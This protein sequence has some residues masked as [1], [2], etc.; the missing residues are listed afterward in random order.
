[1]RA[2]GRNFHAMAEIHFATWSRWVA[3]TGSS[4]YAAG[5]SARERMAAAGYEVSAG[6]TWALNEVSSA[7]RRG[8]GEARANLRAFLRGLYEGD[9]RQPTPGAVF[10]IGVGQQASDVSLYQASLQNGSPTPPSGQT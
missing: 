7:V 8:T 10:V 2:L 5:V 6:D 3:S 9:G 4:W 1:L